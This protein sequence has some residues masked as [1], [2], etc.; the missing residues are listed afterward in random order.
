M[1]IKKPEMIGGKVIPTEMIEDSR[2][3]YGDIVSTIKISRLNRGLTMKQ[4]AKA[5]GVAV[6]TISNM[7]N[8]RNVTSLDTIVRCLSYLEIDIE[9]HS[10]LDHKPNKVVTAKEDQ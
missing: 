8:L 10:K 9:I 7:E 4:L 2:R 3:M 6:M 1:K 5:I